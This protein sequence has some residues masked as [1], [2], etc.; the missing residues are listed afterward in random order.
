MSRKL[1]NRP[2]ARAH[3]DGWR[4]YRT[5]GE[6]DPFSVNL[7]RRAARFALDGD[8]AAAFYYDSLYETSAANTKV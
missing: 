4:S 7:L 1:S 6:R 3:Q 5:G 8:R 2:D